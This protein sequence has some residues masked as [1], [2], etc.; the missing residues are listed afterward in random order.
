MT[1]VQINNLQKF[2][3]TYNTLSFNNFLNIESEIKLEKAPYT[4]DILNKLDKFSLL[5]ESSIL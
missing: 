5:N 1:E 3:K 2:M 4:E